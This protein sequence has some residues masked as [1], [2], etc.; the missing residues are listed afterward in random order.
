VAVDP[1]NKYI[2]SICCEFERDICKYLM[3]CFD[4]YLCVCLC[5]RACACAKK[6]ILFTNLNSKN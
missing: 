4:T 5:V 3:E 1:K 2:L 6:G